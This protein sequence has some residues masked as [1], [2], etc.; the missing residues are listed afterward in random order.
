MFHLL[1]GKVALASRMRGDSQA[2]VFLE[3]EGDDLGE[4]LAG[5]LD[6]EGLQLGDFGYGLH[7]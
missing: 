5:E 2:A 7:G 1:G 6:R 3:A 4:R